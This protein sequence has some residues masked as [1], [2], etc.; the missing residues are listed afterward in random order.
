MRII[1]GRLKGR[2]LASPNWEGL[3]P[4]SDK[5]R[6]TLFNVLAGRIEDARVLDACAGTGAIGIE[7]LSRG[8]RS[9]LAVDEDARAVALMRQNAAACG[10]TAGYTIQHGEVTKVLRRLD[11]E[12]LDKTGAFDVIILD[13]PYAHPDLGTLLAAV[14]QRAASGGVVVLERATRQVLPDVAALV[15]V[16]DVRSGDSTLTIFVP[17]AGVS[18]SP[19]TS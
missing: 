18:D 17:R 10:L 14:A 7:A 15:R 8:A 2:R 9:V 4:T 1:A 19:E 13:P 3:R 16:R 12:A 11:R 5:L 6:E